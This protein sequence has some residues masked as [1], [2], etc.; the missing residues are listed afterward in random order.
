M[1]SFDTLIQTAT[2]KPFLFTLFIFPYFRRP[3]F[4]YC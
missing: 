4:S 2:V 1:I 3:L